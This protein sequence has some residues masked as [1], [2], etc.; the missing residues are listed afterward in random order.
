MK[1][2]NHIQ[3]G[4]MLYFNPLEQA[5]SISENHYYRWICFADILQSI[6]LKSRLW[7]L[8]LPH[9]TALLLPLL[10]CQPKNIIELGLG[11]GNICRFL[12]KITPDTPLL[13][14][15]HNQT[16][17]NCFHSYFNPDSV[18]TNI[19]CTDI[20]NWF[21]QDHSFT[22]EW[23]IYDI[24]QQQ[25]IKEKN[26]PLLMRFIKQHLTS[27]ACVSINI[28]DPS[29]PELSIILQQLRHWQPSHRVF[30]F[31]VAKYRNIII[32]LLPKAWVNV[33]TQESNLHSY[34]PKGLSRHWLKFWRYGKEI[35]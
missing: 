34:L 35:R 19:I 29:P 31:S 8:T 23:L 10:F 33:N 24:Y 20:D 14:L 18:P 3:Q 16:V 4:K 21:S 27:S 11:G 30:Y 15:E 6:M 17:I 22:Q 28:P 26:E 2:H 32:H 7:W 1:L 12:K 9:Q 5:I 13:S 25:S